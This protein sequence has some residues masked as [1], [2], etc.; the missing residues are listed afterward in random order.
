MP[1]VFLCEGRQEAFTVIF[2]MLF[3][4]YCNLHCLF[5]VISYRGYPRGRVSKGKSEMSNHVIDES[6]RC[7]QC[8]NP[9]CRTGC[10]VHTNIPKA[11]RLL[12]ESKIDEAGEML[13]ENNPLS[14]V[15]SF[16][17]PQEMQCEGHCVLGIKGMP[18]QFSIIENYISDYYLNLLSVRE[19]N[20]EKNG[21]KAAVIG[22][23]PAGITIAFILAK[24]G[25]EITMYE[26]NDKVGGVMR[27]GIPEFRLP[28]SVLDRLRKALQSY[29]VKI[30]PN[31]NIGTN[32][33]VD[34]LFRDGFKSV[35]IGT[36]VWRPYRLNLPGE[37]L[38]HVHYAIDYLRN[39]DVYELGKS[40]VV[41]GG[42]NT[43]MD[44]ARTVI[45]HGCRDVTLVFNR[46]EEYLT[47]TKSEIEFTKADGARFL[48]FK[49]TTGFTDDGVLVKDCQDDENGYP[50]EIEG[51]ESLLECDSAIIAIGQ[52][53]RSVIVSSTKGID[54][55]SRGLVAVDESGRTTREGV[56]ASGDVVTGA[57][58][59]V[60][61]VKVS[62]RVAE[63]MDQYMR[64]TDCGAQN[65]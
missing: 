30:R 42:G 39:P 38:G 27:Y 3:I 15:C 40:V 45:R 26:G 54:V 64:G 1:H 6:K 12:R 36:G 16:V 19:V 37:S 17:C 11:I 55:N 56:F 18:V 28:K 46:G 24:K 5:R 31:T 61:A 63:A 49:S 23:G 50:Q 2:A 58:T 43:A 57:K 48:Y 14:L 21:M 32:L 7:L 9:R 33:T 44:V 34:D 52:G 8:K 59:V 13:F 60:A 35:F 20:I 65:T 25:Y 4:G 10:P 29:G 22:T 51:T 62:K 53:P 47:A 41:I